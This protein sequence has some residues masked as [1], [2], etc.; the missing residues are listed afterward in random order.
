LHLTNRNLSGRK[1]DYSKF[2]NMIEEFF[3]PDHHS[4]PLEMLFK[5]VLSMDTFLSVDANNIAVIHCLGGKGRTGTVIACYL[6]FK[7]IFSD[8][9]ESLNFFASKR[10]AIHKGVIQPSQIR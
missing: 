6:M 9:V 10:S 2:G 5:I 4:P 7:G 8:S 3:F 1:Y